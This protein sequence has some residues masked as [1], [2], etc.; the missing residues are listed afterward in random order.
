MSEPFTI[1]KGRGVVTPFAAKDDD[2]FD[3]AV[4]RREELERRR[5]SAQRLDKAAL[6]RAWIAYPEY[7][8]A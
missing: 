3:R 7:W 2:A 1:E 8:A 4:R 6:R 5:A